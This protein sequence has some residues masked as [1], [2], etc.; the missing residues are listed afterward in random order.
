MNDVNAIIQWLYSLQFFGIKLGLGNT[1]ALCRFFGDP[2]KRYPTIHIAGTNGKGSTSA[3]IASVLQESGLRVGLYTSPHL[4][5]FNERIRVNGAAIADADVVDFARAMRAQVE[6]MQGTFFEATTAMAFRY[7]A[8]QQVDIA[9]IETGMGGRLDSTNVVTPVASVIT[10][11]GFDHMEHLGN[12]LTSIAREK[13]GIIKPRVPVVAGVRDREAMDMINDKARI[14]RAPLR[15]AYEVMKA[16]VSNITLDGMELDLRGELH[17]LRGVRSPFIGMHQVENIENATATLELLEGELR[18]PLSDEIYMRGIANAV[19]NSGLRCRL[20]TVRR[21]PRIVIDVAHNP[22]AFDRVVETLEAIGVQRGTWVLGIMKD[23]DFGAV[24]TRVAPLCERMFC[25]APPGD[26]ALSSKEL[27][28]AA[29]SAGIAAHDAGP[30]EQGIE[31]A[32]QSNH[33]ETIFVAG[34]HYVAGEAL[35]VLSQ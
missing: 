33:G 29:I 35:T 15:Y 11:I 23:K 3:M 5:A 17:E 14:E 2:Q 27:T 4:V 22:A 24:L 34:S 20:E 31:H 30:V 18:H 6:Q 32:I 10:S 12:D 26:R 9:V 19:V 25:V 21:E 28:A 16:R 1:E 7:F 8:D 13:A